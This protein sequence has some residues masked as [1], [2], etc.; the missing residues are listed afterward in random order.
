MYTDRYIEGMRELI[1]ET[2]SESINELV[3][4][5]TLQNSSCPADRQSTYAGYDTLKTTDSPR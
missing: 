2:E 4:R 3:L 1:A 5:D